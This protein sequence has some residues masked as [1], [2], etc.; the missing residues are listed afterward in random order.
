MAH[1][2]K[3]LTTTDGRMW[4]TIGGGCT[5]ADV[6]VQALETIRAGQPAVVQHTLNADLAG[7]VGL[8]CGGTADFF[9]EPVVPS[10]EAADFYAAVADAVAGRVPA[11]VRT[12]TDWSAGP[13]KEARLGTVTVG[14][15]SPITREWDPSALQYPAIDGDVFV[16][17][18]PRVPRVIVFGVGHVGREIA[19]LAARSGFYVMAADDR[20]EFASSSRVPGADEVIAADFRDVLDGLTLDGDDYVL[21]T[22]RGHQYDAYIVERTAA[23]AARYVG[24]L[25]SRRKKAVIWKAL[26]DAGVPADALARVRVP[27]GEPIGADTPAEIAVSVVAELIRVRRLGDSPGEAQ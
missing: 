8:S 23:S 11:A 16:E 12:A 6:I 9:L 5:E 18:L 26:S 22:T 1:D 2:A 7:D 19:E 13:A 15:G 4:G 10:A 25:G 14:F 20:R 24:M 3:L 17:P 21:A 27:I